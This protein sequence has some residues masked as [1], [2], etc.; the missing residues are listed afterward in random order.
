MLKNYLFILGGISMLIGAIMPLFI[1]LQSYAPTVFTLGAILF[2]TM[3]I[4]S[5]YE[6]HDPVI[7]R[8]RRQQV[9]GALVLVATGGMMWM[10]K[11]QIEPCAN[12]EWKLGLAIGAVFEVYTAFRLP[13]LLEKERGKQ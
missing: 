7:R 10:S 1:S 2:A 13:A 12:D 8:L 4:Q 3:Q 11:L 9:L 6:G 5:R